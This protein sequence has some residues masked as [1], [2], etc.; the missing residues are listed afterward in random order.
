MKT[1]KRRASI[2]LAMSVTAGLAGCHP[3]ARVSAAQPMEQRPDV[4]RPLADA[5]AAAPDASAVSAEERALLAMLRAE[6]VD[7]AR[8]THRTLYTWTTREQAEELRH[9]GPLLVRETSP[10][11][12]ESL[13]DVALEA[14]AQR[15]Q[16]LARVLR[17]PRFRKARFAWTNPWATLVGWEG[18]TY[19]DQLVAVTLRE[20]AWIVRFTCSFGGFTVLDLEGR[21]VD[22][23]EVL[24]H[25]ERIGAVHYINDVGGARGTFVEPRF[26]VHGTYREYVLPNES[27]IERWE[28]GTDAVRTS[29]ARSVELVA[30]MNAWLAMPASSR[31]HRLG[32]TR[33]DLDG[34]DGDPL[35]AWDRALAF[36]NE[37]YAP[38]VASTRAILDALRAVPTVAEFR[39]APA[40]VTR[41]APPSAAPTRAVTPSARPG[42]FA[43]TFHR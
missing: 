1:R 43:G 17:E 39:G 33:W 31:F 24:A 11:R 13:Y 38:T 32:V 37:R 27:M 3:H 18:E 26:H 8:F 21:T 5:S 6:S 10:T 16:Q 9:G 22:L 40:R 28:L 20:D 19:G 14:H 34:D 2:P 15:G 4:T 23:A 36:D 41:R 29:L 30:A 25:P 35:A 12:G 42:T 7:H